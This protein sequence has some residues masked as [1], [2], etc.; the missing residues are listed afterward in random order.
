MPPPASAYVALDDKRYASTDLTRGPGN[1]SI[2]RRPADRA[3]RALIAREAAAL[4]LTHVARL[5]ANLLR[6]V[7]IAE[8][9]VA[10]QTDYAGRNVAHFPRC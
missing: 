3:R 6:P 9:A 1:R 7:P 2:S 5:T 8:L 4:G 10:V